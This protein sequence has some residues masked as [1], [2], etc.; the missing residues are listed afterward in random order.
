MGFRVMA[1]NIFFDTGRG[2]FHL[3]SELIIR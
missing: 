3:V 2:I 1:H